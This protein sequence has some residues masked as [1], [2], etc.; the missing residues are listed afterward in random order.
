MNQ[1]ITLYISIALGAALL[2]LVGANAGWFFRSSP[3]VAALGSGGPFESDNYPNAI[4]SSASPSTL[5]SSYNGTSSTVI[6]AGGHP[7][8]VLGGTYTPKS[9]GSKM[10][11]RLERSI[12]NGVSFL[13]YGVLSYGATSTAV[14]MNGASS[15]NGVP[16]IIPSGFDSASGTQYTFSF[17][18]TLSADYI[19]LSAKEDTTST[20]GTVNVKA[21]LTSN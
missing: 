17:D 5:T 4:G 12:D 2:V 11:L 21:L 18:L 10:Y 6:L 16:Y 1:K 14:Y 3:D 8:V 9:F 20:A 15:T 13:P 7:N 19:R